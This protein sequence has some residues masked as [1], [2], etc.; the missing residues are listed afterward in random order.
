MT[1]HR[2][3]PAGSALFVMGAA[4][5]LICARPLC[6]Q[7]CPSSSWRMG[8]LT[9]SVTTGSLDTLASDPYGSG[10]LFFQNSGDTLRMTFSNLWGGL[11]ELRANQTYTLVGAAPGTPSS[12]PGRRGPPSGRELLAE[13]PVARGEQVDDGERDAL[14][15]DDQPAGG[16]VEPVAEVDP[17]HRADH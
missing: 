15:D 11:S 10:Q 3:H 16:G 13:Q 14:H 9:G 8:N 1:S 6:A 5:M 17:H 4:L 2:G 12:R 7:P